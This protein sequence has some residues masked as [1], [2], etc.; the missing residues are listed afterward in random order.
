MH[1][2]KDGK[3]LGNSGRGKQQEDVLEEDMYSILLLAPERGTHR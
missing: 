3:K 2:Q 1:A